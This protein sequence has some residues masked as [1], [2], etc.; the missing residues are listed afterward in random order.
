MTEIPEHLLRRSR[1]R[2]AALGLGGGETGGAPTPPEAPSSEGSSA[3]PATT[4]SAAPATAA[5]RA[6]AARSSAPVAVVEEGPPAYLRPPLPPGRARVPMFALPILIVLPFFA[7]FYAQAFGTPP[8]PVVTDPIVLGGQVY[9][10]AGC[11][12]CHGANG[13]GG[14]GPKLHGGESKLTFPNIQDQI[15]WVKTGSGPSQG[16]L[17]GD[18]NRAGGQHGPARGAMPAFQGQLTQAQIEAVVTYEREQL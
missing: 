13:E 11:S 2:R 5:A 10:S 17:Y 8:A 7:F 1:E 9:H 12:G 16:K 18:P 4:E 3:V 6:P 14:T 15:N